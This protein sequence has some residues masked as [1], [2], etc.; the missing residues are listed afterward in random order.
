[1]TDP[2]SKK[3][4]FRLSRQ[5]FQPLQH[6]ES[7]PNMGGQENIPLETVVS[8]TP[9]HAPT[10]KEGQTSEKSGLFHRGR[11]RVQKVDSNTGVV[12]AEI[13]GEDDKTALNRMGKIYLKILNFSIITRYMIYVAPLAL[14]LAI[15]IILAKTVWSGKNE[16]GTPKHSVSGADVFKFFLWIEIGTYHATLLLEIRSS[17]RSMAK[18]VGK[19]DH[20]PLR[21][22]CL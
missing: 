17:K 7:R 5:G 1:M 8:H 11:R 4:S 9:S 10:T 21:A 15:P 14:I 2:P 6:I 18:L 20:C 12:P 22:R 19:Q 3:S 16:D 13:T